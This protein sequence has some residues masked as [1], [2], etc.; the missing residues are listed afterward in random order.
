MSSTDREHHLHGHLTAANRRSPDPGTDSWRSRPDLAAIQIR[1]TG[2]SV[3][4]RHFAQLPLSRSVR[5]RQR[6][7]VSRCL[8][9]TIRMLAS[10]ELRVTDR[11]SRATHR[12][13]PPSHLYAILLSWQVTL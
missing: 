8:R 10:T 11:H 5:V 4:D 3:S 7:D 9:R 2:N 6:D 13:T 12:W 1:P